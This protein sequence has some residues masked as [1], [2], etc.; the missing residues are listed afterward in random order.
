MEKK[1]VLPKTVYIVKRD[2]GTENEYLH[3]SEDLT[4]F[5]DGEIVGSYILVA[6]DVVEVTTA[7]K[8]VPKRS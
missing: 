5:D 6:T 2:A 4:D 7:L 3:A 1:N 8:P